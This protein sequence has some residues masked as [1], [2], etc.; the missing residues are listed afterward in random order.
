MGGRMRPAT[1]RSYLEATEAACGV[2]SNAD[3]ANT[4][5]PSEYL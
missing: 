1:C 2:G 4:R 3:C 5:K